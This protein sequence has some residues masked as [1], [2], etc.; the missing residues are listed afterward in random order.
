MP[1]NG[2]K[3]VCSINTFPVCSITPVFIQF[4]QK[5]RDH[6]RGFLYIPKT[7]MYEIV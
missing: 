2:I 7:T 3:T 4:W 6:Q 5:L 1:K